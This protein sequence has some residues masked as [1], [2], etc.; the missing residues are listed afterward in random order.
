MNE[1]T[2]K[3]RPMSRERLKEFREGRWSRAFEVSIDNFE[4]FWDCSPAVDIGN[5]ID[6]IKLDMEM[7]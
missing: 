1:L 3:I 2:I 7:I 4:H 5:L 6:K